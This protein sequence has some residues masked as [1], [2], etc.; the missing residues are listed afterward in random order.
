LVD[1]LAL[2]RTAVPQ[3]EAGVTLAPRID[4]AEA[5]LDT[6]LPALQLERQVRGFN[7]APGAWID[8]AGERV[9]ILAASVEPAPAAPGI[10]V[11]DRLGLGTGDGLLRPTL[12]QRAGKPAR[13]VKA[14]LNGW[15]VPA[16]SPLA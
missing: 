2:P 9:K 16:G 3:P 10:T 15:R 13:P 8:I 4:K 6:S 1:V 7:P 5:H 14:L 11:D 12:V